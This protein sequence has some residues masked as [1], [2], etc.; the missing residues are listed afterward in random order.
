MVQK[1][2]VYS[3][4]KNVSKVKYIIY[5]NDKESE[6]KTI[7]SKLNVFEPTVDELNLNITYIGL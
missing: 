3:L 7:L 6:L 2:E 5:L 4:D 1:L